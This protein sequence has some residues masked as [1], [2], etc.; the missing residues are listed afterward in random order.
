MKKRLLTTL[1]CSGLL[2]ACSGGGG[3]GHAVDQSYKQD[4]TYKE[5]Y[6]A[7][8]KDPKINDYD[9]PISIGDSYGINKIEINEK[10]ITLIPENAS[11][12]QGFY[13]K[14]ADN[15]D[16]AVV[17]SGEKFNPVRFGYIKNKMFA[18]GETSTDVPTTGKASYQGKVVAVAVPTDKSGFI[19]TN[20]NVGIVKGN[21]NIQVDFG[22]KSMDAHFTDFEP[23]KTGY[24]IQDITFTASFKRRPAEKDET[25]FVEIHNNLDEKGMLQGAF[26][27]KNAEAI[28][29]TFNLPHTDNHYI[30][31]AFG[32]KKQ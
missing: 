18:H 13:V 19:D 12:E 2:T 20:A 24:K 31:A 25:A 29:G 4:V 26:Y 9:A 6:I 5:E 14:N 11:L 30:E 23:D 17:V 32:A 15:S 10:I 21:S 22:N 16:Q 8:E 7:V 28:G 1:I 27:G 3:G